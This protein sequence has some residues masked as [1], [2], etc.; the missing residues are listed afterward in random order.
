MVLGVGQQAERGVDLVGGGFQ[1]E[2][3]RERGTAPFA[4]P[5]LDFDG[6]LFG[7]AI[8]TAAPIR[9]LAAILALGSHGLRI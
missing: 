4:L 5:K 7:P 2:S 8:G 9:L 6:C 1:L 3:P